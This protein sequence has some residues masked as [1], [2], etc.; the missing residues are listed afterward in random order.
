MN[1][2][3][4]VVGLRERADAANKRGYSGEASEWLELAN[5]IERL[6]AE[7]KRW[8]DKHNQAAL[9]FQQENAECRR[10]QEQLAAS[11]PENEALILDEPRGVDGDPVW[12]QELP[13][14]TTAGYKVLAAPAVNEYGDICFDGGDCYAPYDYGDSWLAYR[15]KPERSEG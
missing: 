14:Y 1:A 10:L 7:V 9:N 5:L 4:I 3:E 13:P 15:R 6:E 11:R 12:V 2:D 8:V